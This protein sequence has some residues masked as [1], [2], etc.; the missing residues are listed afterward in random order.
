MRGNHPCWSPSDDGDGG[1]ARIDADALVGELL[2]NR[3]RIEEAVAQGPVATVF[4][5]RDDES[6]RDVA[7]KLL[8]PVIDPEG[9]TARSMVA[10]VEKAADIQ[11]SS[12]VP[13]TEIGLHHGETIFV[14][15]P[16]VAAETV[17]DRLADDGPFKPRVAMR[18]A[19]EVFDAL[20]ALH[21]HGLV[22]LNIKP[23]NIFLVRDAMGTERA[24]L[25][26]TAL[27]HV[28]GLSEASQRDPSGCRARPEYISPEAVSGRPMDLLSDVYLTG[29]VLYEMLCGRPAFSGSD[30][31]K[32]AR[33]HA[34]ERPLS[35][36]IVRRQAQ[37][38]KALDALVMRCLEKTSSRRFGS[39]EEASLEL[40]Q[41][42]NSDD[43]SRNRT[44]LNFR[45][46]S[47][48]IPPSVE[49]VDSG[50]DEDPDAPSEIPPEAMET[51]RSM[52]AI[53]SESD[54]TSS[55][56]EHQQAPEDEP[57]VESKTP[58]PSADTDDA[59][60]AVEEPKIIVTDPKMRAMTQPLVSSATRSPEQGGG[61]TEEEPE[62]D[63]QTIRLS[64]SHDGEPAPTPAHFRETGQWFVE[65][66]EELEA[67]NPHL[68]ELEELNVPKD[69]NLLPWVMGALALVVVAVFTFSEEPEEPAWKARLNSA[70]KTVDNQSAPQAKT[71]AN[72]GA[73]ATAANQG[74]AAAPVAKT[75][76]ADAAVVE[77]REAKFEQLTKT[78][79]TAISSESWTGSPTSA[80]ATLDKL[81]AL[82]PKHPS[83]NALI[84]EVNTK[85]LAQANSLLKAGDFSGAAQ[86]A[87]T[88]LT[89]V[90]ESVVA[91]R[92]LKSITAAEKRAAAKA[93]A[94]NVLQLIAPLAGQHAVEDDDR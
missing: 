62:G 72:K 10:D 74:D 94:E 33:R 2:V 30:F 44:S 22:H 40:A 76:Q 49:A 82:D 13:V 16:F 58:D 3:Y 69:R 71:I 5:A 21:S 18:I 91:Q 67:H 78:V 34:I 35:P 9:E 42:A 46:V 41:I 59:V 20:T 25:S 23:E 14:V 31:R 26:G 36:R 81:R 77:N 89:V 39:A 8:E 24:V 27:H 43:S 17:A 65:S 92:L 90:P 4:R 37:I 86:S 55:E 66:V 70:K 15:E 53:D 79:R 28:M 80:V 45:P 83:L 12:L 38:S 32:T 29:L 61:S 50:S 57:P 48:E 60:A 88:A 85:L 64:S 73:A 51:S 68:A 47:T 87:Q 52:E 63:N 93:A 19:R 7:V 56:E 1:G 54:S 11:H 6:D 75:A 84:G